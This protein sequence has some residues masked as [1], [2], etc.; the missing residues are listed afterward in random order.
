MFRGNCLASRSRFSLR[1]TGST[2][3]GSVLTRIGGFGGAGAT[4]RVIETGIGVDGWTRAGTSCGVISEGELNGDTSSKRVVET[5][6][7]VTG[8][9]LT[10]GRGR[11]GIFFSTRP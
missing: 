4:G 1:E 8:G 10:R 6:D 9:F 11:S 7:V 2:G 5:G 3:V